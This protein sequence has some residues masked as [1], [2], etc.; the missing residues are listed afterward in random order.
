MLFFHMHADFFVE[1]PPFEDSL[2][3]KCT[4]RREELGRPTL[5]VLGGLPVFFFQIRPLDP[6]IG[7]IRSETAKP[8]SHHPNITTL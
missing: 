5:R 1:I 4:T 6:W 3:S 8:S 7:W 2:H